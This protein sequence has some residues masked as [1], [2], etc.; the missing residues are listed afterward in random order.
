[1]GKNGHSEDHDTAGEIVNVSCSDI[2]PYFPNSISSGSLPYTLFDHVVSAVSKPFL[3]SQSI[4]AQKEVAMQ[5][6]S[7]AEK[8]K[9]A[10]IKNRNLEEAMNTVRVLAQTGNFT[11]E[12]INFIQKCYD[13]TVVD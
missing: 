7:A 11:P 3:I 9:L 10:E 4:Q 13:N 2:E 6:I 5:Q 1:M 12:A 8:V